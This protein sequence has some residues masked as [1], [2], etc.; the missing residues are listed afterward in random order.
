MEFSVKNKTLA[1]NNKMH[2]APFSLA[3]N[4][5]QSYQLIWRK[6]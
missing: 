4:F 3:R 6:K 2:L 1:M 5:L